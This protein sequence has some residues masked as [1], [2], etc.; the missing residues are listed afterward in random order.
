MNVVVKLLLQVKIN[1]IG[2]NDKLESGACGF[3]T[4]SQQHIL[5]C[6]VLNTLKTDKLNYS[7]L[8]NGTET[9]NL[10]I[11]NKFRKKYDKLEK[12]RNK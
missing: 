2:M 1:L 3:E 5:E 7:K 12:L 8:F 4:E 11:A 9:E 10:K 6:E